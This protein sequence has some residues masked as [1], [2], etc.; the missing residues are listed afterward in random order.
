MLLVTSLVSCT[1]TEYVTVLPEEEVDNSTYT[2][3]IYGCGGGNLD[4]A[5]ILNIQEALIA[6]ASDRVK[7]TGQ[8][9]FSKRYQV[10]ETLAGA[11]RF[12]VGEPGAQW[13]EPVEVLPSDLPLHQP[14]TLTDFINWS[15]E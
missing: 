5:M 3:M 15:K 10:E 1:K 7:F 4:K 14:E 6:G 9:K 8:I 13:Y 12:I 11:Q 2:I